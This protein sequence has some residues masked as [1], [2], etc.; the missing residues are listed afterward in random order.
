M[1]VERRRV[2]ERQ[3]LKGNHQRNVNNMNEHLLTKKNEEKKE[4]KRTKS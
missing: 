3:G 1:D 4:R 2:Q